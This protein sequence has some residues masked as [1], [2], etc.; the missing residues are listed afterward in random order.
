MRTVCVTEWVPENY[1]TTRTTYK[2][3]LVQEKYTAYRTECVPEV[4]SRTVVVNR[5]VPEVREE[6]RSTWV[7]VPSVETRT[8]LKPVVTC[9]PVTTIS[10]K[11]VDMGH[12]ECREVPC[13]ESLLARWRK[14]GHH[15]CC[16]ECPPPTKTVQVWCP[17]K[18]WVETPVTTMVRTC[19]MVPTS[20][21]VT[22]CHRVE[23]K[24]VVKVNYCRCVAETKVE[25]F[26]VMV[27][28]SVAYPATRTVARCVPVEE[29]VTCTRMVA[30]VVEKQVPVETCCYTP[31]CTSHSGHRGRGCCK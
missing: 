22:V 19:Q 11:C 20:V 3:E 26:T 14:H 23:K 29:K 27:S 10:R 4:H 17:N 25:N 30:R 7:S 12:Y 24:E 13:R 5:M 15:D 6:V 21:Q 18:V 2:T 28:K 16:D 31:C 8:V 1:V 9:K